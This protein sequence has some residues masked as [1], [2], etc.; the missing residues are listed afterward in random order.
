MNENITTTRSNKTGKTAGLLFLLSLLLPIANW[1][2]TH[3]RFIVIGDSLAT[4]QKIFNNSLLFRVGIVG[5]LLAAIAGIA[6]A[7]VLYKMFK[8]VNRTLALTAFVFK[9]QEGI[10]LIGIA[11]T[12]FATLLFL[13]MG[14]DKTGLST[15]I[16][17]LINN[18]IILTSIPGIFLGISMTIFSLLMYQSRQIPRPLALSGIIA[19]TLVFFYDTG[20]IIY[21][22]IMKNTAIQIIA[23]TP[24]VLFVITIGFW[25]ML[26]GISTNTHPDVKGESNA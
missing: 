5:E 11:F 13:S 23:T 17:T 12:H 21:P 1:L 15:L 14:M 26:K 9:L 19:Y 7:V 2:L 4:A 20:T 22:A 24:I 8:P 25:L 6:L 16:G 3:S 18:H 10:L